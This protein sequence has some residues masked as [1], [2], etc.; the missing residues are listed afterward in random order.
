MVER[1]ETMNDMRYTEAL[2]K[3]FEVM[4]GRSDINEV[5][6]DRENDTF[7]VITTSGT[8]V[9]FGSEFRNKCS[10]ESHFKSKCSYINWKK[11]QLLMDF[12]SAL[13]LDT[14]ERRICTKN[15]DGNRD[16]CNLDKSQF[17]VINIY[18]IID[19]NIYELKKEYYGKN[20]WVVL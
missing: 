13:V 16:M 7:D 20:L 6:F 2:K 19:R 11:L 14:G 17:E 15:R 18:N 10:D 9:C 1:N 5:K 8:H 4:D 3:L 12:V